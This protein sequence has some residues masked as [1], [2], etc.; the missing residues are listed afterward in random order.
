MFEKLPTL[1][2]NFVVAHFNYPGPLVIHAW[3]CLAAE[4]DNIEE[5]PR[6]RGT[7]QNGNV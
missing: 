1:L 2:A 6:W 7:Q 3:L 5:T 4:A